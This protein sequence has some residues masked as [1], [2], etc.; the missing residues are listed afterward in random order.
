[1]HAFVKGALNDDLFVSDLEHFVNKVAPFG[2][3]NSLAQTLL[4]LTCPGVPDLYQGTELPDFSLV[5]PDNRRLV[6]YNF[7]SS[8]LS[9]V[10]CAK[11]DEVLRRPELAKLWLIHRTLALRKALPAQFGPGAAY[12]PLP[13]LGRRADHVVA[14]MR[15][16]A[17]ITI[18][19]RLVVALASGWEDTAITIPFGQWSNAFDGETYEGGSLALSKLMARFPMCLLVGEGST[20]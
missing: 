13:A 14:F 18:V 4:K 10:E 15:G 9:M 7:R 19:P 11:C 3:T 5:D 6:D 17:I 8:L 1:V 12:D 20:R 16:R 2:Q